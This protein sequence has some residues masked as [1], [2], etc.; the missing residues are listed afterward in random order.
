MNLRVVYQKS[1]ARTVTMLVTW[2]RE[3]TELSR[4]TSLDFCGRF[5]KNGAIPT[6]NEGNLA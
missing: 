1:G 5:R 4:L 3:A 2:G 6:A